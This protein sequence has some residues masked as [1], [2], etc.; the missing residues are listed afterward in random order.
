MQ[1]YTGNGFNEILSI[2]KGHER[3]K[4]KEKTTQNLN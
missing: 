1:K 4:R 2:I 3:N